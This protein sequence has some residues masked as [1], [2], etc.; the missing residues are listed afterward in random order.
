ME[1]IYAQKRRRN[2]DEDDSESNLKGILSGPKHY[3]GG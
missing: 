2:E 3:Q 1:I